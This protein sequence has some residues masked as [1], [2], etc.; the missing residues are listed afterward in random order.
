M[1]EN[2]RL[3]SA[4]QE[5]QIQLKESR[6]M[7]IKEREAARKASE[8]ASRIKEV[9]VIDTALVDKLASENEKLKVC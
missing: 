3:Q 7:V 2:A 9:P 5:A 6:A 4:L 1:Q 8:E